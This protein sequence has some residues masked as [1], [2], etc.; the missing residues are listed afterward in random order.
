[1]SASLKVQCSLVIQ[2]ESCCVVALQGSSAKSELEKERPAKAA[3][4]TLTAQHIT[5]VLSQCTRFL[6]S[7]DRAH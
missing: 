6:T 5:G 2:C 3:F 1:M 4:R 7:S